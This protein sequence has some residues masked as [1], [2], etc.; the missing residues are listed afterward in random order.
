[1]SHSVFKVIWFILFFLGNV[2][3]IGEISSNY[4]AYQITTTI[5]ANFPNEFL[6]PSLG[7]C[8]YETQLIKWNELQIIIPNIKSELNLT[9]LT[10]EEL[11]IDAKNQIL[12][13]R[14]KFQGNIFKGM[15]LEDGNKITYNSSDILTDCLR[16]RKDG[17]SQMR[18]KCNKLFEIKPFKYEYFT[19]FTF[20]LKSEYYS[21]LKFLKSVRA[22]ITSGFLYLIQMSKLIN[23]TSDAILFYN[24]HQEHQRSGYFRFIPLSELENAITLIYGEYHNSLLKFPYVTKCSNY[25]RMS[26]GV[27]NRGSCYESC[28]KN[29]SKKLFGGSKLL[30]GLFIFRDMIENYTNIGMI[31][32]HELYSNEMLIE[33]KNKA[34][35]TCDKFCSSH[36]CKETFFVPKVLTSS[37]YL[38]PLIVTFSLQSPKID[39]NCEP[40]L[41]SRYI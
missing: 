35:E 20:H 24:N 41:T 5:Q 25:Q 13:K 36:S 27:T 40:K 7:I 22:E 16:I 30:P 38:I 23:R 39:T 21:S 29:E 15:N 19:C 18:G 6:I 4:F 3:Q 8:F 11:N 32:V 37:P 2:Y 17:A 10:N 14:W 9:S 31:T 26:G 34:S 28:M 33:M 12:A 1:M